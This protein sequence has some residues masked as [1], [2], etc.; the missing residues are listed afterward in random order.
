MLLNLHRSVLSLANKN[1]GQSVITQLG[2]ARGLV[3]RFIAG[4]TVDDALRVT[5]DLQQRGIGVALDLLGENVAHE[6]DARQA[7]EG[8]IDLLS[9]A[10]DRGVR[11]PYISVK[12]TALGLDISEQIA[13]GNLRR[14]LTAA[15]EGSIG[16][17]PAFVR[18]DMESSAYTEATVR[19]V[20]Q[21]RQ[22]FDNVGIVLQAYLY[23][24]DAD[25][26]EMIHRGIPVRLVKGAYFEPSTVAYAK[27]RDVDAA[28]RRNL[29]RL[30]AAG[31]PTA[32][33]THDVDMIRIAKRTMR[34]RRLANDTVEFQLLLGIRSDLRDAIAAEGYRVRTYVPFG[35]HWYPYFIRR[36]AERPANLGFVLRNL[37]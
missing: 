30:L 26:E 10:V 29:A 1:A 23:R 14:I 24:T 18:V 25:V 4:E 2:L 21:A 19:I 9:A 12:L 15:G 7:T 8:Y 32:V 3:E 13:Q 5:L 36:L 17:R 28:Y 20:R 31:H 6:E 35:S 34:E 16:V 33:A 22:E 37:R 27:K 11:F